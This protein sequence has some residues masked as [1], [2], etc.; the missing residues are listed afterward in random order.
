MLKVVVTG[1]DGKMG[2]I[3]ADV[4]KNDPDATIACA[5]ALNVDNCPKDVNVY[6]NMIDIKEDTDVI[7]DFTHPANLDNILEYA[8]S[9][10][11]PI[12][13]ATTGFNE[14]ELQKIKEASK[15]IAIFQ[16]YNMALGVNIMVKLVKQATTLLGGFDI[17][18]VEK[19]HNR[20]VDAPSGTA[21]MIANAVKEVLPEAKNVYGR[22]GRN[23]KREKNDIGIHAI[24]GGTIVGEHDAIFAGNDEVLT[25]SHQSQSRAI[26]ANGA[27]VAGK[28]LAKQ[29]PGMYNM[30]NM[31]EDI[32]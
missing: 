5:N 30:N 8:L 31:L 16:S 22:N 28:Y 15:E 12:V 18:I 1:Y 21:V 19:H 17:E 25:I 27:L 9:S 7:I 29:A 2:N 32:L 3:V 4:V 10:K 26:F 24:R 13:L 6:K 14:D 23:C 11:T 20:K